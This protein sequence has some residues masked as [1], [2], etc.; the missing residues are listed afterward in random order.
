[1]L[2]I[3]RVKELLK[4]KKLSDEEAE[5]IRDWCHEFAEVIFEMR[6]LELKKSRGLNKSEK[7]VYDKDDNKNL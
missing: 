5:E 2:S 6:Q 1:M 4:E 7:I 3:Q